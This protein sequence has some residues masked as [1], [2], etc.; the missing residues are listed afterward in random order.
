MGLFDFL[1]KKEMKQISMN[2]AKRRAA[3]GE[4]AQKEKRMLIAREEKIIRAR[5]KKQGRQERFLRH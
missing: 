3:E 1:R 2:E 5:R 4:R